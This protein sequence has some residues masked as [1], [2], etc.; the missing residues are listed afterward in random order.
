MRGH[1]SAVNKLNKKLIRHKFD[2]TFIE[3]IYFPEINK[4][5]ESFKNNDEVLDEIKKIQMIHEDVWDSV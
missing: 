3:E 4:I 2:R 1:I 5:N